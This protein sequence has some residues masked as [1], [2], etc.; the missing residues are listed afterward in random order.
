MIPPGKQPPEVCHTRWPRFESRPIS[1]K[2]RLAME[3]RKKTCPH[4]PTPICIEPYFYY[5]K[6]LHQGNVMRK[7]KNHSLSIIGAGTILVLGMGC[8]EDPSQ[9]YTNNQMNDIK[10]FEVKMLEITQRTPQTGSWCSSSLC[11]NRFKKISSI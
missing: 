9:K 8:D 10:A 4:L 2:R 11:V 5:S 7:Q 3:L 6:L 1:T